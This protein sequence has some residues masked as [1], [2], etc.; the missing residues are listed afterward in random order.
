[1]HFAP[2]ARGGICALV[3]GPG[4]VGAGPGRSLGGECGGGIGD[5]AVYAVSG[6][7]D[8]VRAGPDRRPRSHCAKVQREA[9]TGAELQDV[10]HG[11]EHEDSFAD[12]L[13]ETGDGGADGCG[14]NPAEL[15]VAAMG[16]L[17]GRRSTVALVDAGPWWQAPGGVC[18]AAAGV[19]LVLA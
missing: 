5:G 12:G 15:D 8:P 18:V 19:R 1:M 6:D 9:G 10:G 11:D 17:M 7:G 3:H 2:L 16:R 13:P 14:E 4:R